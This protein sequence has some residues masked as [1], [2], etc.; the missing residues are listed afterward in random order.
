MLSSYFA[1]LVCLS[2]YAFYALFTDVSK[3]SK[4]INQ[5]TELDMWNVVNLYSF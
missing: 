2:G 3:K 4:Q 1:E 5:G